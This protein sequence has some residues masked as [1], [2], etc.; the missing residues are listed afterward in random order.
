M[1]I[2]CEICEKFLDEAY[3]PDVRSGGLA[4]CTTCTNTEAAKRMR[5]A[6]EQACK[7]NW[8]RL[9]AREEKRRKAIESQDYEGQYDW[10]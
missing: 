2:K 6:A 8:N 4:I 9:Q 1:V 5:A 3:F 10:M 7:E